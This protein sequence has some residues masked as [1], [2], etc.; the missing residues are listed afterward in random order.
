MASGRFTRLPSHRSDVEVLEGT[1]LPAADWHAL[2]VDALER[3]A[4]GDLR[5]TIGQISRSTEL[6]TRTPQSRRARRSEDAPSD[7]RSELALLGQLVIWRTRVPRAGQ[8][9]VTRR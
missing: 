4:A 2:S 8:I 9:F 6:L 7:P 3:A 1:G 5:A